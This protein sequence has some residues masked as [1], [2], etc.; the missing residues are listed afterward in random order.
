VRERERT[1]ACRDFSALITGLYSAPQRRSRQAAEQYLRRR[2]ARG[3]VLK[4]RLRERRFPPTYAIWRI[5]PVHTTKLEAALRVEV[6]RLAARALEVG[7][8]LGTGCP[9]VPR[10]SKVSPFRVRR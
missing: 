9:A 6:T 8:A 1:A 4:H 5:P 7:F 3:V 10:N 2:G